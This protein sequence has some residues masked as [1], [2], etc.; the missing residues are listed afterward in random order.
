MLHPASPIPR[1]GTIDTP[2]SEPTDRS[3]DVLQYITAAI[4]IV[5][6]VLLAVLR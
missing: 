6:A 4:A 5:F 2:D 3:M 1:S